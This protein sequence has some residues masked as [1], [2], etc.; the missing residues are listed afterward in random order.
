MAKK[1]EK[2]KQFKELN[3]DGVDNKFEFVNKMSKKIL[4]EFRESRDF[5]EID[6]YLRVLSDNV[7]ED[8]R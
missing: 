2:M 3:L 1:D 8:K 7:P 5:R 4:N 6:V